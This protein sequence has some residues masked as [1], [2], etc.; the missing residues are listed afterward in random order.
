MH[1]KLSDCELPGYRKGIRAF[2]SYL[3]YKAA[4]N[5]H[6]DPNKSEECEKE[7]DLVMDWAT[8]VLECISP[9]DH[10]DWKSIIELQRK[11]HIAEN[12]IKELDPGV[13]INLLFNDEV[14][15]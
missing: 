12:R 11:L 9:E 1:N 7:N 2:F 13:D 4:N 15:E 8:G 3:A 6:A 10:A 5:F 14:A